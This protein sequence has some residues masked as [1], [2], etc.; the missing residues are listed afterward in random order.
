MSAPDDDSFLYDQAES[1]R[2]VA[3]ALFAVDHFSRTYVNYGPPQPACN[4]LVVWVSSVGVSQAPTAPQSTALRKHTV[5]FF[6]ISVGI[7]DCVTPLTDQGSV[8]PQATPQG[9]SLTLLTDVWVL[10]RGL[11]RAAISDTLFTD[12][13]CERVVMRQTTPVVPDNIAGYV[14]VLEVPLG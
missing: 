11:T 13:T 14:L 8:P 12:I 5:P 10:F 7:Y 6:Q 1:V 9:E 2:S 4:E 3:A